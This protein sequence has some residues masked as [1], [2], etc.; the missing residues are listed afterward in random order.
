LSNSETK[1]STEKLNNDPQCQA[2][3]PPSEHSYT[4]TTL[5]IN[6]GCMQ[7]SKEK[8]GITEPKF[9]KLSNDVARSTPLLT[10]L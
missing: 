3:I 9:T 6:A 7:M 2:V 5:L 1:Q 8:S 4:Q 10:T